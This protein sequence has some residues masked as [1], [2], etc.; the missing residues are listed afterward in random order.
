[1]CLNKKDCKNSFLVVA[2][3]KSLTSAK[4]TI[5]MEI[6]TNSIVRKLVNLKEC[7]EALIIDFK[8]K[9]QKL[10]L[11]NTHL[12]FAAGPSVRLKQFKKILDNVKSTKSIICGD[13][14]IFADRK[15]N[16]LI[17]CLFDYKQ[18][19]YDIDERKYFD[20]LFLK[21]KLNNPFKNKITFPLTKKQLDHIL[22]HNSIKTV[23]VNVLKNGRFFSDHLPLLL[24]IKI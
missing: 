5:P 12:S 4:K 19:D 11:I 18:N 7:L 9:N 21:T 22:V 16:F 10:R 2:I 13:F 3:A 14:N 24:E 20:S 17:G 8:Y 1:V 15:Y 23:K 6:K